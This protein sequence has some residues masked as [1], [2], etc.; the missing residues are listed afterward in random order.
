AL[1]A[2]TSSLMLA[3]SLMSRSG[4]ASI[5]TSSAASASHHDM[6]VGSGK[7]VDLFPRLIVVNNR[8]HWNLQNHVCTFTAC[9][10]GSLP[11]TAALGLVFWVEAEVHQRVVALAGF[12]DHVATFAAVASG[13][14]AAGDKL[15]PSE[16]ETAIAAVPRLDPN[17]RFVDKHV[18]LQLGWPG[19]TP[20]TA[21]IIPHDPANRLLAL[22]TSV[23][24][25]GWN[26]IGRSGL[27][28]RQHALAG[29]RGCCRSL[30]L[31]G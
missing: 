1:L 10:I 19:E 21:Q 26:R 24:G 2:G 9:L 7:V 14:T 25:S 29:G 22:I 17:F 5:A 30:R 4:E 31:D 12:H 6:V 23:Y 13:R 15:L 16:G 18:P 28:A 3:R 27:Q 11:V 20:A 8:S